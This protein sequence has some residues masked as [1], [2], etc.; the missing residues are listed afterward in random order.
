[1]FSDAHRKL[2][3]GVY[4]KI[5]LAYAEQATRDGRVETEQGESH[6][7][8]GDGIVSN[9]A[10]G[11]DA[12]CTRAEKSEAVYEPDVPVLAVSAENGL[13]VCPAWRVERSVLSV[14]PVALC[15]QARWVWRHSRVCPGHTSPTTNVNRDRFVRG[16]S[17]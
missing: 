5:T 10:D 7:R 13:T 9:N 4:R 15:D 12:N 6:C 1:M 16:F 11:S 17:S 2:S 8:S 3:L 14:L